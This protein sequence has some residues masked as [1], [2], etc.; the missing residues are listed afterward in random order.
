M[1]K[2]QKKLIL[3]LLS[4]LAIFIGVEMLI[5]FYPNTFNTKA[6]YLNE[7]KHTIEVLFLGSSHT[8]DGINPKFIRVKSANLGYGGQDF[9]IDSALVKHFIKQMPELKKIVWEIDFISLYKIREQDYF[10]YPWYKA[11]YDIDFGKNTLL[12]NISLYSSS[13]DFFNQYL[14]GLFFSKNH[15]NKYGYDEKDDIGKFSRMSYNEATIIRESLIKKGKMEEN[16]INQNNINRNIRFYNYV[17]NVCSKND[18][19]LILMNYP[20]Y[21]TYTH[22][23]ENTEM[24]IFWK[25]FLKQEKELGIEIWNFEKNDSFKVTDFSNE[26]HLNKNGAEKLSRMV[27]DKIKP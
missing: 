8:Q 27:N 9:E 14:K 13:P 17:K 19:E 12:N 16:V 11:Y 10:R 21:K 18:I 22:Q 26:S 4:I 6:K 2:F 20:M 24:Y 15:I 25:Q 3:F 23:F 1:K 5:R 7:N